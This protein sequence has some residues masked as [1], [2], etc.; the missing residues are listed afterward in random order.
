M[1]KV[2]IQD[3]KKD[4]SILEKYDCVEIVDTNTKELKGIYLSQ[5]LAEKLKDIIDQKVVELYS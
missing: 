3:V 4:F 1:D 5:K 2:F